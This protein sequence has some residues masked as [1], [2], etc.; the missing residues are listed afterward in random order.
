MR[1]LFN[2]SNDMAL[3]A[4][5]RQY[6]PPKRVK[7]MEDELAGLARWWDGTRFAGPWGWSVAAK[8]RYRLMGVDEC[9]LPDD[10]WLRMVR[11]LS[12][13]EFAC[14]YVRELLC[15]MDDDRLV[16]GR[17]RYVSGEE[18][19]RMPWHKD[20]VEGHD[21]AGAMAGP[22]WLHDLPLIFKSPWSSS[23]RGVFV[24]R[25]MDDNVRARLD[26]F[27]TA[28][29]GF[30]ADRFY[31]N[32][33]VDFAME[34]FVEDDGQVEFLGY[35]V[36]HAADGGAYGYNHVDSQERLA[37]MIDVDETLLA[38]LVRHHES[39]LGALGYRGVVGVDMMKVVVDGE[40]RVHPCV[41]MNMRMNMGVLSIVLWDR[42]REQGGLDGVV[43]LT[44][45]REHG[46]QAVVDH[47]KLMITY[48]R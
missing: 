1:S 16:G 9:E 46:F 4:D 41:E 34:F 17:M 33:L 38:K 18:W 44:E 23:G 48:K 36:F 39:R 32:K 47:G 10:A 11:R 30:A 2:C 29:G 43:E 42:L 13:R 26:G 24:A 28:Q 21:E 31:E 45:R 19:R 12:S 14:G 7:Q 40:V 20:A 22:E 6:V 25:E 35:S 15:A 3:A 8:Q 5:V 27:V 37:G